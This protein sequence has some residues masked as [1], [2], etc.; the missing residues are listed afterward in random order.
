MDNGY[1]HYFHVGVQNRNGVF[2]QLCISFGADRDMDCHDDRLDV[3]GSLLSASISRRKVGKG[4]GEKRRIG[5][6]PA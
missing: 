4:D 5:V 3:P 1:C 6:S 2:F